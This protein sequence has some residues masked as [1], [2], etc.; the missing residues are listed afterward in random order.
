MSGVSKV[1]FRVKFVFSIAIGV[2]LASPDL[3][4]ADLLLTSTG[5]EAFDDFD[6]FRGAGFSP[7]PTSAQLSSNTYRATGFSDGDGTFGDTFE[8]GDFARGESTGGVTTGGTYAFD[9]GGGDYGVGVQPGG[10]DFTPGTFTIRIANMTGVDLGSI[11]LS[12]ETYFLND[13]DRSTRWTFAI[14]LDD[15]NYLTLPLALDSEEAADATPAWSPNPINEF[16]PLGGQVISNGAQFYIR[17]TG[18]DLAGSG[19]RDEFV[20]TRF[21]VEGFAASVPE[22]GSLGGLAALAIGTL[23]ARRKRQSAR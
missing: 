6:D 9:V 12:A 5:V 8:S 7:T 2:L 22:P 18:D 3:L 4:V 1:D 10:S 17:I 13:E 16:I 20:M 11:N 14:S 19:S 23:V 21:G 15:T